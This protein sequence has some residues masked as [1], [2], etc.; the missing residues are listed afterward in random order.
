MKE[1]DIFS[2]IALIIVII[3]EAF[4][5]CGIRD[6]WCVWG[7]WTLLIGILL[8]VLWAIGQKRC[9]QF[10]LRSV[11]LTKLLANAIVPR[12]L[13]SI[14]LLFFVIHIGWLTNT[15]MSLFMPSDNIIDVLIAAGICLV[16]MLALIVFFPNG[17][18]QKDKSPSK[19]FISGISAINFKNQ[20]LLPIVRMLQLT[21][22]DDDS[23]ELFILHSN[24]YANPKNESWVNKNFTDYFND[25]IEKI[26][27]EGVKQTFRNTLDQANDITSKLKILI[28]MVAVAE[29]P[30][31]KWL[32]EKLTIKFS[33]QQCDYET[34]DQCFNTL[35]KIVRE[36]DN[37]H[38]KLFF[39]ITPGTVNVGALMTLMA[40]DGLRKLY[41][42]IPKNEA[43]KEKPESEEEK[44]KRLVEVN[45]KNIPLKSLLSQALDSFEIEN[46]NM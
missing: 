37:V 43:D 36:K 44:M 11:I 21:N 33:E 10:S 14:Y 17:G 3:G 45:K 28:S 26:A 31:K 22:N 46:S 38:N 19:V 25:T 7:Q 12:T 15:A 9:H 16:G 29:F 41:Y 34:F 42:Y 35:D 23:C 2:L 27:N 24:Y 39:N 6:S 4:A 1:R 8:F 30:Q 5:L 32:L 20:N 18:Q 13:G 40:I